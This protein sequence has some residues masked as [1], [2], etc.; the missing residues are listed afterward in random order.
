[1]S[2]H[3][4]FHARAA[5]LV[6]RDTF[7]GYRQPGRE[8][9]LTR[10]RLADSGRQ[11]AAHQQ[12]VDVPGLDTGILDTGPGRRRRQIRRADGAQG[13]LKSPDWDAT[14]GDDDNWILAHVVTV[15]GCFVNR[16]TCRPGLPGPHRGQ[17]YALPGG[18]QPRRCHHTAPWHAPFRQSPFRQ[19][20]IRD[21]AR[22][23]D[24]FGLPDGR[25]S[26][27]QICFVEVGEN[28]VAAGL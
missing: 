27:S 24:R 14:G 9:G 12:F 4:R 7:H 8:R 2:E 25:I 23:R 6:D 22:V 5:H 1:M 3:G 17:H 28:T 13:A 20:V 19:S 18:V 15:M 10:R 26:G 21:H 11:D 16:V